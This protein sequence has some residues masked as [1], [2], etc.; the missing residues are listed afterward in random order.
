VE[1]KKPF[2]ERRKYV[3]L[4]ATVEVGYAVIGKPGEVNVFS[5]N[6]SA[7]GLCILSAKQLPVDTP[8]QLEIKIPDLKDPIPALARV[9]WQRQAQGPSDQS[10]A[11][12]ETGIEFTGI[13]DFDRFNIKRYIEEHI[14]GAM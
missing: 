8:L 13:S 3:R 6:I 5:K 1:Q 7:G 4:K 10:G 12:F 2:Q 11:S 14:G 9:V